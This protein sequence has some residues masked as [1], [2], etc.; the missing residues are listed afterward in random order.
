MHKGY[1]VIYQLTCFSPVRHNRGVSNLYGDPG[2]KNFHENYI[3]CPL[4]DVAPLYMVRVSDRNAPYFALLAI[5]A[6]NWCTG[7]WAGAQYMGT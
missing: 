3:S 1:A 6:G 4:L 7:A 2:L 5:S